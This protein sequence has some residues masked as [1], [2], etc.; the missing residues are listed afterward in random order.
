[1]L[2]DYIKNTYL[3]WKYKIK[4]AKNAKVGYTSEFEGK[5]CIGNYTV[6]DGYIGRGSY[7]GSHAWVERAKIGRYCSIANN[8]TTAIGRHAME[9]VSQHP[10]FYSTAKQNGYT[11]VKEDCY[12]ERIYAD[13]SGRY[14]IIIGNDVWIGTGAIILGN[15]KIGNG[16]VVAAGTVVTKDVPDYA[17]V[18]GVPAKIIRYR[19]SDEEIKKLLNDSW[20]EKDESWIET[21]VHAFQDI[22]KYSNLMH[23]D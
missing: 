8:V 16:A 22:R 14:D 6:F 19:F 21:H 11:Y 5:N 18:A 9:M 13:E 10:M 3:A 12:V 20:W 15:I 7:I 1:M 4:I 2:K 17:V 23:W